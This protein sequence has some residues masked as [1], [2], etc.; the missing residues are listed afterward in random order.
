VVVV[1]VVVLVVVVEVVVVVVAA[2]VVVV[3]V[4]VVVVVAT[5]T[6]NVVIELLRIQELSGSKLGPEANYPELFRNCPLSLPSNACLTLQHYY[7]RSHPFQFTNHQSSYTR[8][9]PNSTTNTC[10]YCA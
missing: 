4:L 9:Q 5:D 7:F 2:V 10:R 6:T 8:R 3:L 1:I